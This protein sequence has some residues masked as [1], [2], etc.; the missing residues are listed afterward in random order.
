MKAARYYGKEDLRIEDVPEPLVR[1]GAVKIAPAW[2]GICGS[3]LH[4]YL[5]R[6]A[7]EPD[8]DGWEPS[9]AVR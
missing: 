4:V 3:D 1:R 5:L 9:P 6:G 2:T 8:A 7:N